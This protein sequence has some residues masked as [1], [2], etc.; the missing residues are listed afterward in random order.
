VFRKEVLQ[1][2]GCERVKCPVQEKIME[3]YYTSGGVIFGGRYST[4]SS[5][6]S[7]PRQ[8]AEQ[9][10]DSFNVSRVRFSSMAE[11]EK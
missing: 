5:K 7:S 8:R 4:M 9:K 6:S 3:K 11:P 2:V 10:L 1:K